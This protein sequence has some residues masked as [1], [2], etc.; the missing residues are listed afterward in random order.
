MV[1]VPHELSAK[2]FTTTRPNP[3]SATTIIR[4]I[5]I[6]V[7]IPLTLLISTRAISASDFPSCWMDAVRITKS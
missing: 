7:V 2:A 6:D 3:A 1:K 4:R 5:A